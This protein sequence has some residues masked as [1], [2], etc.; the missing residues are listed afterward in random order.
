M[1]TFKTIVIIGT[2]VFIFAISL[3]KLIQDNQFKRIAR[4]GKKFMAEFME[5]G[6]SKKEAYNSLPEEY[7]KAI[8]KCDR[9]KLKY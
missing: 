7:K 5:H 6:Q 4:E 3:N 2:L 1:I 8:N 9:L